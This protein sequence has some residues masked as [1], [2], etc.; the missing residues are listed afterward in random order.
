MMRNGIEFL[1]EEAE[2]FPDGSV[3]DATLARDSEIQGL[4][5][6]GGHS[7]V[8]FPSGRMRLARL[9]RQAFVGPVCCAP[10]IVYLHEN[11]ALLNATLAAS[12]NIAGVTVP[13][14]ERVTLDEN[15]ELLEYSRALS[16][17]Q[18]I[19]GFPC[20]AAFDV[21]LYPVGR[22][23]VVVLASPTVIS[24]REYPRGTQL[25]FDEDGQVFESWLMD[26]DS[27][28]KYKQ[29][30]FGAYEAPFH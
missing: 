27:G 9:S 22:P 2:T 19:G 13:A 11:G 18:M 17:D 25:F 20:A 26:L 6:A 16:A 7:V 29:R 24:G 1:V 12:L 3:H 28:Q 10:G 14:N 21:W 8:F 5:C 4:P 15:G 23:S 30:V